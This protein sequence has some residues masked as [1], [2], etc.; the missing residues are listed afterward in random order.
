M[1]SQTPWVKPH[2]L[3]EFRERMNLQPAQVMQQAQRLSR[4]HY[5]PVSKDWIENWELGKG[6]P[7]L[8]HLET[9]SEIYGCPVGYFF[10]D[11]APPRRFPL[12]YRGLAP[13]KE[14][15]FNPLTEQ[16]LRRFLDLSEWI[17]TLIE[18]YGIPWQVGI[19]PTKPADLPTLVEHEHKRL[20]FTRAVAQEW[21]T[22]QD[23]LTW[24]RRRIEDQGVFCIEMKLEPGDVR[25][26]SLWVKSRYPC[27]LINHQDAETATGRLFTL[28]HEYAHLLTA[29][30][31]MTCDFRGREPGQAL[32]PFANHFATRMLVSSEQLQEQLR[33]ANRLQFKETWSDAEL[34]QLRRPLFVS[35]DVI[36]IFLQELGLASAN[37]YQKK[38][39]QWEQRKPGG[40]PKT[41]P[42]PLKHNERKAREIGASMIRVLL[43]LENKHTLPPIDTAYVLGMKV[44]KTGEFLKWARSAM[45]LNG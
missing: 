6:S 15:H 18:E 31:G 27:I 40:R 22:A 34:D 45:S 16:T 36:A 20:G 14:K 10:L 41:P 5:A 21:R 43:T 26:A 7:N 2:V 29:H 19:K 1:E 37:F 25:G 33:Q 4:A 38:R 23:A 28:L 32:E 44:E 35:R 30:E 3:R 42:Q 8:E 9:L 39:A 24:W 11:T 17:T 12:S 13:D